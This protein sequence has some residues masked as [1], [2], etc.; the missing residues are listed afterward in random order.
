MPRPKLDLLLKIPIVRRI[1][2]RKVLLKGLGL[3]AARLA[4]SGSAPIPPELIE[5]YRELGL[6]LLEGYGMSENFAYSHV[7]A[8]RQ[9]ARRLRR[10]LACP[11]SSTASAPRARF[12]SR[13]RPT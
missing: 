11:A 4:I 8:A 7:L 3:D 10:Q 6:E 1:C 12:R 9:V 2:K 13:A 5:W